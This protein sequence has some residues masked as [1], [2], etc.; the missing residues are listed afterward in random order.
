MLNKR[1]SYEFL[2]KF[3]RL[4][5]FL[6]TYK[7][8][9]SL[10]VIGLGLALGMV[11]KSYHQRLP[12]EVQATSHDLKLWPD[13]PSPSH[14]P[15]LG[16]LLTIPTL[17]VSPQFDDY[18]DW[19]TMQANFLALVEGHPD[20]SLATSLGSRLRAH[21]L[22]V[23][24]SESVYV[25]GFGVVPL[26]MLEANRDPRLPLP[27]S[28]DRFDLA[29]HEQGI[30]IYLVN[31]GFLG[32]E[33]DRAEMLQAL[34]I[35]RHEYQHQLQFESSAPGSFDR[36]SFSLDFPIAE[37][38]TPAGC[39]LVWQHER[40]AYHYS[41]LAAWAYGHPTAGFGLDRTVLDEPAFSQAVFRLLSEGPLSA[42][43]APCLSVIAKLAGH[44]HPEAYQ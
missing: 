14:Q 11:V 42:R 31:P 20:K 26:K 10:L 2:T 17:T 44:P 4:L 33:R 13:L 34:I 5:N 39:A 25:A 40:E 12:A 9:C 1:A 7:F 43:Y 15:V 36:Q 29:R 38:N 23:E 6:S 27:T 19:L 35:I 24:I 21:K 41:S 3:D 16:Q 30:E 28:F 32:R 22:A 37:R 8:R 18:H